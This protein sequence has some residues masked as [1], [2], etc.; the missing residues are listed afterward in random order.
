MRRTRHN[1]RALRFVAAILAT[2]FLAYF[3]AHC[4]ARIQRW[5]STARRPILCKNPR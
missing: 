2:F 3:D 1:F 4:S 5:H